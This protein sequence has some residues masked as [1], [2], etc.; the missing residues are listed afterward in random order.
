MNEREI[1]SVMQNNDHTVFVSTEILPT[2]LMIYSVLQNVTAIA[3]LGIRHTII[4]INVVVGYVRDRCFEFSNS[5]IFP[6]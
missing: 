6:L 4:T 3:I 2:E 5:E 1:Y